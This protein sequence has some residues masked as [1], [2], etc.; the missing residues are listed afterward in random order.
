M[1]AN[2]VNGVSKTHAMLHACLRMCVGQ[3]PVCV[4]VCAQVQPG[5]RT[6]HKLTVGIPRFLEDDKFK[7]RGPSR[8]NLGTPG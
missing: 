4:C 2:S 8:W 6:L 3:E 1:C 5:T 7:R